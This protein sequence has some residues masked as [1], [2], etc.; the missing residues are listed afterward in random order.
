[1]RMLEGADQAEFLF[2]DGC[3][4][5]NGR[6]V[7]EEATKGDPRVRLLDNPAMRIPHGLNVGLRHARGRYVA[8]MDA[9]AF[10]PP[11]YLTDGIARLER[12]GDRVDWVVGPAV[13]SG[14]N[15]WSKAVAAALTSPW[16]GQGG[17]GK[18]VRARHGT[19]DE[20][21]VKTSVFAGVW[22]RELLDELGGW[23]EGWPVNQDSEMAARVLRRGG[24][25][26][27]LSALAAEYVPRDTGRALARQYFRYGFYRAKTEL[28]HPGSLPKSRWCLACLPIAA[29]AST[30]PVAL[31]RRVAAAALF[32]YGASL[33]AAALPRVRAGGPSVSVGLPMALAVMHFSWGSGFFLGILRFLPHRATLRQ[34]APCPAGAERNEVAGARAGR[35]NRGWWR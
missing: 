24:R 34:A 26:V 6:R 4:R 19:L 32:L 14:H 3:S 11:N 28:R 1:M 35:G 16:L 2:I 31:P 29:V 10:Y 20:R 25:I 15:R 9:H 5:D 12:E 7:I 8:R 33:G 27:S 21:V 23:D 13:P 17:V 18:Y 22:R 30:A